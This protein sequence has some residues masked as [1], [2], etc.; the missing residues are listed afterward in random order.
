MSS[1]NTGFFS[2]LR[3]DLPAGL[4]VFLVAVPLC[5]GIALACEAPLF[6]GII[7]GII[8]G[9]IVALISGS[10]LGVSGPAAGLVAIVLPAIKDLGLEGFL[11]AVVLAG[12]FQIILGIV[13]AGVIGYYFPNSVIKGMLSGIG[14]IIILKNI[15]HAVGYDKDPEGDFS[16]FQWDGHNT[17]SELWYMLSD[18]SLGAISIAAIS[19]VILFVWERPFMKRFSVFKVVQGPLVVVVVGIVMGV[20]YKGVNRFALETDEMVDI[21]IAK[22]FEGMGEL[23]RFPDFSM[24]LN[25]QVLLIAFIIAVVASLETLLCVEATDKLDPEKRVTPT[26][27]ELIAQG[28]GNMCSGLIGGLPVTQ[29]IVRSS[30]NIQS[31]GRTK[32]SAFFHG[33]LLLVCALSIPGVLNMV[34]LSSLAA[35]LFVVGYKLAKPSVMKAMYRKGPAQFIPFAV[36]ILGILFTDLL[37]G[38]GLGLAVAIIQ[39]LWNNYKTPYHFDPE[40]YKEGEPVNIQLAEDVSFLNKAGIMKTLYDLPDS[41][42]VVIDASKAQNVHPDVLEIIHDFSENAKTRDIT[43]ELVGLREI[44]NTNPVEKFGQLVLQKPKSAG[45]KPPAEAK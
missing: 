7:A 27:R 28:V 11:L 15:P 9:T 43:L 44:S 35:I 39:I 38:I 8:G 13:K 10:P 42:H 12:V 18:L 24:I 2:N 36:T 25:P 17:F 26:N 32:A 33:V 16:F 45:G 14:L 31:G 23:F 21:P 40:T 34:P 41:I 4:V 1:K 3:F 29:V 37:I 6:S 30:A 19:L 22:S 5:L 20:L